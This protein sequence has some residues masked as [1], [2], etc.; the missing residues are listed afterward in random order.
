MVVMA[1]AVAVAVILFRWWLAMRFVIAVIVII[2][3][4]HAIGLYDISIISTTMICL[5]L[6][7]QCLIGSL[8]LTV[9]WMA[10]FLRFAP[11]LFQR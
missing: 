9:Q 3:L 11:I 1:V 6:L 7:F 4:C 5:L 8:I 10:E 2:Q